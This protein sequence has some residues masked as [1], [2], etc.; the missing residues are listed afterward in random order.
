VE[1]VTAQL[2]DIRALLAAHA[3]QEIES[4]DGL[5]LYATRTPSTPEPLVFRPCLYLVFSGA[6]QLLLE[7]R[8]ISYGAGDLVT[9]CVDLPVTAQ[10]TEA[11]D[12]EPYLALELAIDHD[13]LAGLAA[14]LAP[15]PS[16]PDEPV[17]VRPLPDAVLDPVLRLL[18][19]LDDPD[20]ARILARDVQREILYRVLAGPDGGAL[21]H[22]V[23]T[24]SVLARIGHVTRWMHDHVDTPVDVAGLADRA[25]MSA[26]TFHRHFKAATGSSPI[27]YHKHLRLHEARRR[28]AVGGDSVSRIATAVGYVSPS[29]FSRD[30]KRA[31]G[32]A[33]ALDVA[34]FDVSRR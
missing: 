25:G 28:L 34:A 1:I 19:L 30:Y 14:E 6:K 24:D 21:L 11:S 10:V 17:S 29:Q 5:R 13:L 27:G 20:A 26:A 2:D 15:L 3:E 9:S 32:A 22:L 18:R 8:T 7:D 16:P 4:V 12:D 31:F 33:P 23:R